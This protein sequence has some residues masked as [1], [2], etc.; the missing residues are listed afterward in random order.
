MRHIPLT[1][2]R[3]YAT[4]SVVRATEPKGDVWTWVPQ[5]SIWLRERDGAQL[6][7]RA[8]SSRLALLEGSGAEARRVAK[9]SKEPARRAEAEARFD[10]E[11]AEFGRAGH[12]ARLRRN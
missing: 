8:L 2:I 1:S 11:L 7:G 5:A 12:L 6:S 10:A 9:A 3:A 4:R